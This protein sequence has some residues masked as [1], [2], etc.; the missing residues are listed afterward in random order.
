MASLH[1]ATQSHRFVPRTAVMRQMLPHEI[2]CENNRCL[3]L[4]W[5]KKLE[6]RLLAPAKTDWGPFDGFKRVPLLFEALF[7]SEFLTETAT[8]RKAVVRI[9]AQSNIELSYSTDTGWSGRCTHLAVIEEK[10]HGGDDAAQSTPTAREHRR[11]KES[12][13]RDEKG[14]PPPLVSRQ[15][16]TRR[17]SY[18]R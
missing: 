8:Q 17:R 7:H 11:R 4:H 2:I 6:R 10:T 15:I 1:F 18:L 16:E 13:R 12:R 5:E 9:V 3:R 14:R